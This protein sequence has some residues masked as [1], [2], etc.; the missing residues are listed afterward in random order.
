MSDNV[1]NE[2]AIS[3]A[4]Y[5]EK[6]YLLTEIDVHCTYYY[7]YF[8]LSFASQLYPFVTMYNYRIHKLFIFYNVLCMFMYLV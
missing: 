3:R 1:L 7:M 8:Y 5:G 4:I 2:I 6:K